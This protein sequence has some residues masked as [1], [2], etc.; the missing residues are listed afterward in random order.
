MPTDRQ[1]ADPRESSV[2]RRPDDARQNEPTRVGWTRGSGCLPL[3]ELL[4]DSPIAVASDLR[5]A[6]VAQRLD[7]L[8]T[9]GK[10][11]FDLI[12]TLTP[13]DV[14]LDQVDRIVVAV[15]DGPNSPLATSYAARIA[16]L[17]AVPGFLTTVYRSDGER[18]AAEERLQRLGR[19]QP[20]LE[21]SVIEARNV[22]GLLDTLDAGSVLVIGASGGSWFH[23]QLTGP[24][25]SLLSG[26]PG[27]SIV[28]RDAPQ[29]SFQAMS[30]AEGRA[31]GPTMT[32]GDA[33]VV[34]SDPV[35]PVAEGG[36]LVGIVRR[37]RMTASPSQ[38]RVAD[39]L[40]APVALTATEP[41]E[42]AGELMTFL[43]GG[44]I[45]VVGPANRLLGVIDFKGGLRD[46]A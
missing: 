32:V 28:V 35:V 1:I 18:Q 7:L 19:S 45:P 40:E 14:D 27:G 39:H 29:R 46:S 31:I 25:H 11:G 33:L 8:V 3:A 6:S 43:D 21:P 17:L 10:S 37:S 26:A 42:H 44:P 2:P 15:A 12:P 24:G 23:R 4:S 20:T 30:P 36:R 16:R 13:R 41:A 34:T 22:K 9:R 5:S 38:T